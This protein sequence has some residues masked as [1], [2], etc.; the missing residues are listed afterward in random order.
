[1]LDEA[2]EPRPERRSR[3]DKIDV[4]HPERGRVAARVTLEWDGRSWEGHAEGVMNPAAELRVCAAAALRAV[5][6]IV[7][8]RANFSV[9]GVKEVRVFDHDLVVVLVHSPELTESR[10][11]GMAMITED[12]QRAAA[13]AALNAT[14]RVVGRFIQT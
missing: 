4:T 11:I 5:E 7:D 12:R 1:M 13:M 8:Q 3:F 9:I 14:N 2:P 6:G 10:F